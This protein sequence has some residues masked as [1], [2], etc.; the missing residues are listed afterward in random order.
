MSLTL[1]TYNI[2]TGASQGRL[3]AVCAVIDAAAPDVVAVQELRGDPPLG[4]RTGMRLHVAPPHTGQPV[5]LLV[6]P[7]LRILRQGTVPGPF[8]HGAAWVELDCEGGP[9]T[10]ISTHLFPYWGFVRLYEAR[11]LAAFVARR[12]RVVLMGDCNSLDPWTSYGEVR[13]RHRRWFGR[14]GPDTR[15]MALLARR[16]LVDVFRATGTGPGWTVPTQLGGAEFARSRLDYI[17]ASP[18]VAGGFTSCRVL[19]GGGAASASDH[20]P[21]LATL[22]PDPAGRSAP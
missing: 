18:A 12:R 6:A 1:M 4:Q 16:G 5:G 20:F 7:H 15:A 2:L 17:L 19:T 11:R 22:A 10:V 8:H 21:V 14:G 9:L 13:R 3:D